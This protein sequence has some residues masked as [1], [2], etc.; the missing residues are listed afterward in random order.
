MRFF[1]RRA[2]YLRMTVALTALV[3]PLC[4]GCKAW[5]P[6]LGCADEPDMSSEA[7]SK[8][9]PTQDM[10]SSAVSIGQERQPDGFS[11]GCVSCH[12]STGP[13][14]STIPAASVALVALP[15]RYPSSSSIAA[16]PPVPPPP[17]VL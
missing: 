11:C 12:G 3:T 7:V 13:V 14:A 4:L 6:L 10:S 1:R 8:P 16:L 2:W 9:T 5:E 15:S 17:I